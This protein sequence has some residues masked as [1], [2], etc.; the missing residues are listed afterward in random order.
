MV[1]RVPLPTDER[2]SATAAWDALDAARLVAKADGGLRPPAGV[3][4]EKLVAR[5]R[6]GLAL[7]ETQ[8]ARQAAQASAAALYI[9]GEAQSAGQSCAAT[10]SRAQQVCLRLER[11]V[12][13]RLLWAGERPAP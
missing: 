7:D 13:P 11:S 12:V 2:L 4:A 10:D 6:D 8:S 5:A 3:D 1:P 9:P